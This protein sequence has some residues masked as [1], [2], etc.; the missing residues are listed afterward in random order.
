MD[1][2]KQ[3][4]AFSI[5]N[6]AFEAIR[7]EF[8]AGR[9]GETDVLETIREV[10]ETTGMT[11]DPHTAVGLHVARRHRSD[12]PMVSP[13]VPPMVALATAH[14]AKFPDAVERATGARPALPSRMGDLMERPERSTVLPNDLAALQ[15]FIQ[16][17]SRL[18]AAA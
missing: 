18:P 12:V 13:M 10:H 1:S 7:S 5:E 2:L 17:R 14:P 3:A 4:G 11:I 15:S 6:S 8:A 9:A 16:E